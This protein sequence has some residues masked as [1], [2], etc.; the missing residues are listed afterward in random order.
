[1]VPTIAETIDGQSRSAATKPRNEASRSEATETI[2][3]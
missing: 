1:V 2:E 3:N